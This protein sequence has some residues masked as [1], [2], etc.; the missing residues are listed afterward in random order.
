L[1]DVNNSKFFVGLFRN[2]QAKPRFSCTELYLHILNNSYSRFKESSPEDYQNQFRVWVLKTIFNFT[3]ASSAD[4]PWSL[5]RIVTFGDEV[6]IALY[7]MFHGIETDFG[8]TV[9]ELGWVIW[10]VK[11]W[12]KDPTPEIWNI[13]RTESY[14]F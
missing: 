9:L 7:I 13:L 11:K 6:H 8:L 10:M 4:K 14:G 5:F 1:I 3:W 2:D 12:T